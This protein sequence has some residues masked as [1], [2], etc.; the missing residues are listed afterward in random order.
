M[1]R[2]FLAFLVLILLPTGP[3]AG[4][5]LA[6]SLGSAPTGRM[7]MVPTEYEIVGISI[8]GVETETMRNFVLRNSGL[9]IGQTITLPGDQAIAEAIRNIYELRV[10][11]DVKILE[12]QRA[13]T[14]VFLVIRV[15]EEPQLSTYTFTGIKKKHRRDLEKELPLFK[16]SRVR[17]ADTER[18]IQVIRDYFSKKG[19]MLSEVEVTRT[20]GEANTVEL[21]FAVEIGPKVRIREVRVIGNETVKSSTVRRKMKKTK[22]RGGW[23]FWRSA[24]FDRLL[25]EEDKA[26]VVS[27]LNN[28]GFYD[29]RVVADSV[30]L[31]TTGEKPG[32]IVELEV[33]E[34][35]RY[36]IRNIDWEGN[37]VYPD[38]VLSTALGI[39]SGDTYNAKRLEQNLLSNQQSSDVSSL[40][41]N[42][43]YMLFRVEPEVRVIEGDSLDLHYDIYEGDIFR[44]GEVSIAG[45]EKTKEHVIRR[46]LYTVPGQT[47]SRELI[48][49]TI[50]RLSQLNYFDQEKLGAGPSIDLDQEDK[51]ADL[52]YNFDE[53]GSDQLELSG[54]YGRFG[55]ILMLRFA[56]NNFSAQDIFDGS[57]WR[58]LPSG[59]GQ[60]LSVSLQTSGRQYQ[61][62]SLG[63]TEPWFRGRP[64]P[65]GFSL[66]H[67]RFNGYSFYGYGYYDDFAND[68]G[69]KFINSQARVFYEQRLNWPDDKFSTS[70]TLGYQHYFNQNFTYALPTGHSQQITLR[71][72]LT[73]SSIDHPV[74]P[75]AGSTFS[76]SAELALPIQDFIQYHKWSLKTSWN[77]PL[78][79]KLTMGFSGDFGYIGSLTGD[80]VLFERYIVGGSP[81]D[82]QGY[83]NNFGKDIVYMRSYPARVLGPRRNSEAVGGR[84]LNKF[85]SELRFLAVQ[86]PQL[87][88]APYFFMDAANTWDRFATYNPTQLYRSAGI[89]A[90]LFLPILGMIEIAYGYN[91]DQFVPIGGSEGKHDGSNRWMFQF[92]LG[93][94]FNQ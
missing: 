68:D 50:R 4:Q 65:V 91:F 53:V 45:N 2:T 55:L 61:S 73:R 32:L 36:H 26:N 78:I 12:E 28:K 70:T 69:T 27:H 30:W 89:G 25:Y 82:V 11:S 40:Y 20:P 94:G 63:F 64:T 15:R 7:A 42:R 31:D 79:S 52:I 46:E 37:T 47:F 33:K 87:T 66:S 60:Q 17:P 43:G 34:G 16:G 44:I 14:G 74:F 67:S 22:A 58:P 13:G 10:F 21:E 8:E 84:I 19:H 75:N 62:Y 85:T 48:Q 54:T 6:S 93:Q 49:E 57:S 23:A 81:F 83:R 56:F 24:K 3:A 76:L 86:T 41:M 35:A 9:A 29:A 71:Q 39:E 92:T 80:D 51:E 72:A 88:A 18:S 5:G 59:D 77:V 38:Q 1:Q 90:R